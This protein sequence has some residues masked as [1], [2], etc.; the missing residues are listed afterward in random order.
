MVRFLAG[1]WVEAG[2]GELAQVME[3]GLS[4]GFVADVSANVVGLK[5]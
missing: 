4:G 3:D 2:R 1:G 5:E